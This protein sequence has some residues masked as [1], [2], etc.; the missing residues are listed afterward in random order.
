MY[1]IKNK[2]IQTISTKCQ[3]Q[4]AKTKPKWWLTIKWLDNN[5]KKDTDKKITPTITC[6]PCNPVNMKKV[7]A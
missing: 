5:R 2:Q 6:I 4:I 3:Y 7:E 1:N